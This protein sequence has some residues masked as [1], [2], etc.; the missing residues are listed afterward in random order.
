MNH[1]YHAAVLC[2]SLLLLASCTEEAADSPPPTD[3]AASTSQDAEVTPPEDPGP[4]VPIADAMVKTEW[5]ADFNN[6]FQLADY[7]FAGTPTGEGL[8]KAAKSG[9]KVIVNLLTEEQTNRMKMNYPS[10]I[11]KLGFRYEHIPITPDTFSVADVD[12]FAEILASTDEPV[13]IHCASSNRVGGLW[14]AYLNRYG[15]VVLG[16][17]IQLGQTAGLSSESMIEAVKRVQMPLTPTD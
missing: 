10:A 16:K 17:A 7:Y 4:N 6:I 2:S 1:S 14:A 5:G 12:R 11:K 9:V 15:N 13:L 8:T 3:E